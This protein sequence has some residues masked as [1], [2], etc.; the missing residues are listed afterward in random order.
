MRHIDYHLAF[1]TLLI[2]V[3]QNDGLNHF[4]SARMVLIGQL[5]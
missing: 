5:I 3:L 1:Q 2:K 4:L